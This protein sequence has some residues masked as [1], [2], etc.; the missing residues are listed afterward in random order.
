MKFACAEVTVVVFFSPGF[1]PRI[2]FT[3]TDDSAV[4]RSQ[5]SSAARSSY[6]VAPA[7]PSISAP[8]GIDSQLSCSSG[9]AGM[10]PCAQ[11]LRKPTVAGHDPAERLH[12]RVD[13]V[14][15]RVPVHPRVQIAR[16]GL[17]R[18]VERD[19]P[20]RAGAEL[21]NVAALHP[22]VEDHAHVGPTL[23]GVDPV[24]DRRA[25]D[26]L[27]AV[28]GDADVH[29]QRAFVREVDRGSQDRI[30]L[31]LVVGDAARE[32]PV[33]LD[34]RLEGVAVPEVDRRR[35]LHV[36]VAVHEHR[37]RVARDRSTPGSRRSP[38]AARPSRRA[39]PRRPW[40]S[41]RGRAPI[42]PPAERRRR[43][44]GPR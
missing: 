17:D 32:E 4:V 16:A 21:R 30:E 23:V 5:N 1:P 7:S 29:G 44:S 6:G 25:A 41:G 13:R 12:Q 40:R 38:S 24:D 36:E 26:L 35:R 43:G 34:R 20:S 22:A 15:R 37:R 8:L 10:I 14:Q 39:R 33:V 11:R 19:E 3:S 18:Q 31:T 28:R 9:D 42:R 2:P 27:L